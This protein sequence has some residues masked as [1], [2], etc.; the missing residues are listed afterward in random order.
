SGTLPNTSSYFEWLEADEEG[1]PKVYTGTPYIVTRGSM[2][3]SSGCG[4]GLAG[5]ACEG[6]IELNGI[7]ATPGTPPE[8]TCSFSCQQQW[9]G[10]GHVDTE[11]GEECDDGL[12]N[13]RADDANS[14]IGACSSFCKIPNFDTDEPP[15]AI[16]KN[17]ELIADLTCGADGSVNNGSW[18]P[19]E[20]LI[21]CQQRPIGP[22]PV[23]TTNV[24]LTCTDS[25]G[26]TDS[27]SATI[28]VRDQNTPTLTLVGGN[29]QLE[30]APGTY[31]DPGATA[32]DVCEG[33]LSS[34]VAVTGS[35][36]PG[37]VG[38]YELTYN[39]K[40]SSGNAAPPVKRTVGVSDTQKPTL[41]LNGLANITAECASPY[42]DPGATA[43]D[44]CAGNLNS[45]IVQTGSV[46]TAVLGT[47]SVKFNVQDPEGNKAS[48]IS[49]VV[50]VKDTL[51]PTVTVNGPTN[52][53]LECGAGEYNDEGATATDACAGTLSTDQSTT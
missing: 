5:L 36:N 42:T 33:N 14:S 52:V 35:V 51:K 29:E 25:K 22:Y 40:D 38:Y 23:G 26:N 4:I 37:A 9:C 53:R 18:D 6:G 44:V 21:G 45:A 1:N 12:L 47:Y 20:D 15:D 13:G 7:P 43:S 46:D 2:A 10:D 17:L 24:T 19:D 16:C 49:R 34:K 27:C 8:Q 50:Q 31:A 30:C 48:E 39:V 32:A 28:T 11:H 3:L 41:A